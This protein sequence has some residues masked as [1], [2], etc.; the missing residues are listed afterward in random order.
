[1]LGLCGNITLFRQQGV[2]K[3]RLE[4]EHEVVNQRHA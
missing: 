4:P 3:R 1:M 2:C